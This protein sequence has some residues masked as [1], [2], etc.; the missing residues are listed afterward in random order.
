MLNENIKKYRKL[1]GITQK[2]LADMVG[3]SGAFMS[4]IEK[5]TNKPSEDNLKKIANALSISV[6]NLLQEE[7]TSPT[8][9][10]LGLLIKL[11]DNKKIKWKLLNDNLKD[12]DIAMFETKIKKVRY[13]FT[14]IKVPG[15]NENTFESRMMTNFNIND[16]SLIISNGK[17]I[18]PNNDN[19]RKFFEDLYHTIM[20]YQPDQT[21]I[22][23]SINDLKSLLDD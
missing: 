2:E 6:D 7:T 8:I 14:Y 18:Y 20:I 3:I 4:L 19:E 21:N 1:M 13:L 5:G 16:D 22:Y 23:K 10:L 9:E 17:P 15:I 11:T 12:S